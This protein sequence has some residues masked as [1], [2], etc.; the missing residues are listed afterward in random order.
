[1]AVTTQAYTA[2]ATWTASTLADR[3]KSAFID[4]GLMLDWH[5][6]FLNTVENRVLQVVNDAGKTYGTIYY[7]FMFTT[8]GVF[9]ATALGWDTINKVPTGTQYLDFFSTA[10]NV[11]TNHSQLVAL[12]SATSCTLTR[13]TSGINADVS[14][15]LIRNGTT[16]QSFMLSDAGFNASAFVDQN[17][18]AFNHILVPTTETSSSVSYLLFSQTNHL[19]RTYL[20][21]T[22]LRGR[23]T[24]A[25]YTGSVPVCRYA[26]IGNANNVATAISTTVAAIWL[27]TADDN[28]QAALAADHTPVFT[29]PSVSPYMPAL[30]ADFGVA[31]YYASNAMAVQDTLVVSGGTQEWEMLVVGNN[32]T[33]DAG[34]ILFLAR[35]V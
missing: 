34:R 3:F 33:T 35:T 24:L 30:P 5:D 22:S 32:A 29:G 26:A 1:M 12:S 19:R 8:G 14:W 21:A 7:W 16:S 6:S 15:F 20:G 28:T 2:T 13:Y 11:T 9:V 10:T 4:A 27:P 18:I 31:S 25:S 17:K 23:T